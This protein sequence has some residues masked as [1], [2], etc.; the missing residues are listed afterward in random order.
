M[1]QSSIVKFD[2]WEFFNKTLSVLAIFQKGS[3]VKYDLNLSIFW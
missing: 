1:Q 2:I 3:A